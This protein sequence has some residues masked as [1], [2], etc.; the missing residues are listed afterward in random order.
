MAMIGA[1]LGGPDTTLPA[2][3]AGISLC[4]NTTDRLNLATASF[5][6]TASG[7]NQTVQADA[8]GR[9][10]IEVDAGKTYTVTLNHQG[11]YENDGPQTVIAQ[12]R[13]NYGVF[14][15]LF[16]YPSVSTSVTVSVTFEGAG[17]EGV[18]VVASNS[19]GM[20]ITG[21]TV[22]NGQAVLRGLDV[23]SWT[24]SAPTYGVSASLEVTELIE[25]VS[26]A[27]PG[28][29]VTLQGKSTPVSISGPVSDT[30]TPSDNGTVVFGPLP[31]GQYTVST[32]KETKQV[33]VGAGVA[34]TTIKGLFTIYGVRI[35]KSV[36]D[37]LARVE[38]IE[39]N[40]G[41]SKGTRNS[42][43]NWLTGNTPFTDIKPVMFN[44]STWTDLNKR[45]LAQDVNGSPVD[46]TTLGNDVFVEVPTWWL[47]ITSDGTYKYIRFA[48]TQ[49]DS[50]YKKLASLWKGED[51]GMF[52]RGCFHAYN[53]SG[54]TYSSRNRSPTV[55]V[56]TEGFRASCQARGEGYDKDMW[57]MNTYMHALC[58]LFF[59]TTN[60]QTILRGYVNASSKTTEN[61]VTFDNDLGIAGSTSGTEMMSFLWVNAEW[62]N[63][64]SFI[65]GAK[66]DGSCRL[67]TLD[68]GE[69][70]NTTGESYVTH[71][72]TPQSSRSGYISEMDMQ[73]TEV[74]FFPKACSGSSSTYWADYGRVSAS[75]FPNV[76]GGWSN[77]DVAGPFNAYFNYSA[78]NTNSG[79][80]SRLSYRAGRK[81]QA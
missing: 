74:G 38:Y 60:P 15:D 65:G 11:S 50:T 51:V 5:T 13:M 80:S 7:F 39:E 2:G 61:V 64:Y 17:V 23:G 18:S 42:V 22:S 43:G 70:D 6:V 33:Q 40:A 67:Q 14:F 79:V 48:D 10:Y 62:G 66:T 53:S 58:T 57:H 59:G 41:W 75:G 4:V 55:S 81:A 1:F 47:S 45:N 28:L 63:V 21:V 52:H 78:S 72:T 69:P 12:S 46:I 56:S 30:K 34:S 71:E 37:P 44:G 26:L 49:V 8:S 32:V 54:K 31:Q 9:A 29:R 24:V 27:L 73:S 68:N 3:K 76:G 36:A 19:L 20:Q 16:D 35:A 25:S 77:G